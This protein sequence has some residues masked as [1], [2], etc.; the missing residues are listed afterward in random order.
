VGWW[1]LDLASLFSTNT[2]YLFC[3]R[4][5]DS[6]ASKTEVPT[7]RSSC[8]LLR[9]QG[10]STQCFR[11]QAGGGHETLSPLS[12]HHQD[13]WTIA[14]CPGWVHSKMTSEWAPEGE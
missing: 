8:P 1:H 14:L 2:E 9:D 7:F 10:C 5:G 4:P 3:S 13:G 6:E 12:V 11:D